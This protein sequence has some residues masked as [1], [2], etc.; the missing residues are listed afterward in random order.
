MAFLTAVDKSRD[1]SSILGG[2]SDLWT[3]AWDAV[4]SGRPPNVPLLHV[5]CYEA[6]RGIAAARLQAEPEVA[7]LREHLLILNREVRELR[8]KLRKLAMTPE[9]VAGPSELASP[10]GDEGPFV[11]QIRASRSDV[12]R[13]TAALQLSSRRARTTPSLWVESSEG[14]GAV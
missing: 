2:P 5:I 4:S 7:H 8:G 12:A 6:G 1:P 9:S 10:S 13:A 14:S 11:G 3:Y